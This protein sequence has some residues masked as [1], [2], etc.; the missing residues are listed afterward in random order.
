MN[1][2]T[3]RYKVRPEAAN[4]NEE[5]IRRVF[6]QLAREQPPGLRYQSF[7]LDDGV[8]FVH[9]ASYDETLSAANPLGQLEAFRAF[10]AGIDQRCMEPPAVVP[11]AQIG[12]YDS[13]A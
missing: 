2:T 1:T 9:I 7:R 8:S 5:L 6:A 12:A 4:E 3:V 13:L 11:A 10:V